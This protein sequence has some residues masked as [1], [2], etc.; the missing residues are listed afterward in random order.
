M[1]VF[2]LFYFSG[3]SAAKTCKKYQSCAEVIADYPSGNFG[4]RD[5][6]KDGIPCENICSSK[7]QVEELLKSN[8]KYSKSKKLDK[9]SKE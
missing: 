4:I 5:R 1:F 8:S 9:N 3:I 7:K 2:L 6:D